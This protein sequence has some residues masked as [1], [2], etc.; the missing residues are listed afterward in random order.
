[1]TNTSTNTSLSHQEKTIAGPA[2]KSVIR[3]VPIEQVLDLRHR[4]MYPELEPD[5]VKLPDDED[6][7][8]LGLCID[9]KVVSVV[10][11]FQRGQTLQ[12]RKF[13]TDM[14]EQGK[15]YGSQLLCHVMDFAAAGQWESIWC[16]AR[17]TA[18]GFYEKTGMGMTGETWIQYGHEFIRMEKKFK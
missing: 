4:V 3:E 7:L 17:K 11:L 18:A 2:P 12:F 6:G 5:A 1:M 14:A 13:A 9:S 8:H 15:G 16:N 10:S